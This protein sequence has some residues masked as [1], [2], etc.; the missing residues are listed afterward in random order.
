LLTART[1]AKSALAV[2]V[3]GSAHIAGTKTPVSKL[4][5]TI[6]C[7]GKKRSSAKT[8]ASGTVQF[9]VTKKPIPQS[10]HLSSSGTISN[11]VKIPKL[12]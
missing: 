1:K 11:T 6:Y 3:L 12:K 7:N 10:C 9:T 4:A 5:V 8:A 2:L